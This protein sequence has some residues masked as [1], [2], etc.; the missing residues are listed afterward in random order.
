VRT[1]PTAFNS[2]WDKMYQLTELA[3]NCRSINKIKKNKKSKLTSKLAAG[4][5]GGFG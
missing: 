2:A 1:N 5:H 3:K 4:Y